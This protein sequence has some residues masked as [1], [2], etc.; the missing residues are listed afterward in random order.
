VAV[1]IDWG[2]T[3]VIYI[4]QSDLT[5]LGGGFYELDVDWFRKELK[6]LEDDVEGMPFP[7]THVH[8]TEVVLSGVTYARFVEIIPPYTVE[9]ENGIYTVIAVGA[10]HNIADVKVPN[11]VSLITQNSAGL[12]KVDDE[13]GVIT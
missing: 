2:N 6:D 9:F 3:Y 13:R 10:N 4:P 12:I 11:S 7:D 8:N 1:S 5:D